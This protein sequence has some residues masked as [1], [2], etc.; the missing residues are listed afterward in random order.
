M[1]PCHADAGSWPLGTVRRA[2]VQRLNRAAPKM[3]HL[4]LRQL[5]G[6]IFRKAAGA[7][8]EGGSPWTGGSE[9]G[10]EV[11]DPDGVWK[12]GGCLL[13]GSGGY[14]LPVHSLG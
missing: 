7:L 12:S 13:Q 5:C 9:D 6:S 10:V 2:E 11:W 3:M 1:I 8:N 14:L 4:D